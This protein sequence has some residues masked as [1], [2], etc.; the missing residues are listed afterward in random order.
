MYK[1]KLPINWFYAQKKP[2]KNN[3]Y[4][5]KYHNGQLDLIDDQIKV[6]NTF[7]NL[8]KNHFLISDT[9][10]RKVW[11]F[12]FDDEFNFIKKE[13]WKEYEDGASPDGGCIMND[14][15]LI[16]LCKKSCISVLNANGDELDRLIIDVPRPSNCKYSIDSK[17][18]WLTS[19]KEKMTKEDL[20]KYPSSGNTFCYKVSL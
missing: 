12:V 3:G 2:E 9:K 15:V 5:Y 16:T 18:L 17:E 19:A 1:R 20:S 7:I 13:L 8:Y 6:P 10:D 14:L 11:K 4:V